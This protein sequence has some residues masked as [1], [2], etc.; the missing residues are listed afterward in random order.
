VSA[1][2]KN[3]SQTDIAKQYAASTTTVM[4]F[5][6][7]LVKYVKPNYHWLP[8]NIAFDDFKSGKFA[9]SGMS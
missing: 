2:G 3:I 6:K 7:R 1:L 4:R 8:A 5:A 9:Q